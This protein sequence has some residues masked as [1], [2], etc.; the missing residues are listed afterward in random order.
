M[1]IALAGGGSGGHFYPLIAVAEGLEELAKERTLIE[2]E[3]FYI[4]PP[5]F[6]NSA[7]VEHDIHYLPGTAGRV[8][9]YASVLNFFDY[10]KTAWGLVR[11]TF[12]LFRLFPD[13]V[14]SSG[15]FAAFPTLFAARILGIPVVIYDA[16]AVPGRV[17]L[18]SARFARWIALAH[19]DAATQFPKKFLEKIARTG[20][21]I[22][23]EIENPAKE[24]GHEFLKLDKSVPTVFI[25]GGS[26]GAV[27]M[28]EAV[29]SA[30]PALVERYNV[31]H[32]AGSANHD[33]VEGVAAVI[34]KD[35]PYKERYRSFGL[36]NTL[37]LR[38]TAGIA[39][40]VVS[41][42]GSGTIFEIA[43]WKIPAILV[44]IPTEISHDQTE[45]AFSYARAG[46]ATVLEQKNLS[47]HLLVAEIGRI[48]DDETLRN[49]MR[50]AATTFA[51][52][53]AGRKIAEILLE[54]GL[55]HEKA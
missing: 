32:Q 35:S 42:A 49:Q 36:L 45:N 29:L 11:A 27:A 20:H 5:A 33:E 23:K 22:R 30:L 8:R 41:R 51:R 44:P 10:F 52:P 1:K 6:D 24:G 28:N 26:Q 14:F 46:A 34:L 55:E 25:M 48:M 54:T 43:S 7:L 47:P 9:R 39:S 40:V 18:W 50:E 13:V 37:A 21:P 17:S 31:V 53:A 4:G 3:F 16:D 38:M 2:P 12:Q 19:P 15:G